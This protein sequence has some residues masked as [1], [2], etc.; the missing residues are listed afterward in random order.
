[1]F[2]KGVASLILKIAASI[3]LLLIVLLVIVQIF[4]RYFINV[5]VPQ[6]EDLTRFS[7]IFLTFLAGAYCFVIRRH[8]SLD[9]FDLHHTRHLSFTKIILI[10]RIVFVL[11]FAIAILLYGGGAKALNQLDQLVTSLNISISYIYVV[12]PVAGV[13]I[14]AASIREIISIL[15]YTINEQ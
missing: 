6:T 3:P 10:L 1:M 2:L 12:V 14:V 8:I 7:L 11:I 13:I 15:K 9:F 4:S 5:P